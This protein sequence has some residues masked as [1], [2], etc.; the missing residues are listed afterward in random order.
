MKPFDHSRYKIRRARAH[1]GELT[2]EVTSYLRRIPFYLV[3]EAAPG[4]GKK[5]V[6]RVREEVPV[7]FSAIIG[8]VIHNLRAA[9]DLMAVQL[10]RLN[11]QSDEDVYFP[12][13][14]TAAQF[15]DALKSRNMH[16]ASPEA[17]ALLKSLKPYPGGNDPLRALHDLDIMD[18]HQALIPTSDMI[19]MPDFLGGKE[20]V[21]GVSMGPIRD[22]MTVPMTPEI[23]PYVRIGGQYQGR[24]SMHFPLVTPNNQAGPL[25]AR[26]V[27]PALIDLANAIEGIVESFANLY[28]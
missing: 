13:S 1:I 19:G 22:G 23:E 12:F 8:D 17:I 14:K 4:G 27:V 7:E 6:V 3:V 28:R 20:I 18:K 21:R 16:R 24:F 5:W 9:L 15:N 10:V 25:G 2:T 11:N 26:E